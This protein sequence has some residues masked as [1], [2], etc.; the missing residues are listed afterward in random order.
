MIKAYII[1]VFII[2][3]AHTAR[4]KDS[5]LAVRRQILPAQVLETHEFF[6]VQNCKHIVIIFYICNATLISS[7]KPATVSLHS[8]QEYQLTSIFEVEIDLTVFDV[9]NDMFILDSR[10]E[11]HLHF[12]IITVRLSAQFSNT[13]LKFTPLQLFP[14]H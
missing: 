7:L 2:R 12:S 13:G 4:C 1:T 3:L 11:C 8:K 14:L 9:K 10:N 5:S 6:T